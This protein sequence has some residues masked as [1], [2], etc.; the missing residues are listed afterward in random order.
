[1]EMGSDSPPERNLAAS[2]FITVSVL[3]TVV[4]SSSLLHETNPQISAAN[5]RF[6]KVIFYDFG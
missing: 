1:M 3:V 4:V 5:A 2:T 6:F